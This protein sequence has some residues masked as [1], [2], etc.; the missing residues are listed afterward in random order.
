MRNGQGQ[1]RQRTGLRRVLDHVRDQ[2]RGDRGQREAQML[3]PKA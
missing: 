3:M 1:G 2:P